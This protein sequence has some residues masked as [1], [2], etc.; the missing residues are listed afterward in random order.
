[1]QLLLLVLPDPLELLL[2][3]ELYFLAHL[4]GSVV[5]NHHVV[6][7]L[8][9]CIEV[10]GKLV[11]K[12]EGE[13]VGGWSHLQSNPTYEEIVVFCPESHCE[14]STS[15]RTTPRA[16]TIKHQFFTILLAVLHVPAE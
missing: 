9:G 5:V 14:I 6:D 7:L 3:R 11:L 10:T 2:L 8:R 13:Y 16:L 4:S 12:V 1:M 15:S